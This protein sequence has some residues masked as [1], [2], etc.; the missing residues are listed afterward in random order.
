MLS[1]FCTFFRRIKQFLRC[2]STLRYRS[3]GY[4]QNTSV[5]ASFDLKGIPPCYDVTAG[6]HGGTCKNQK[7]RKFVLFSEAP[8]STQSSGGP[9]FKLGFNTGHDMSSSSGDNSEDDT[10][11]V[12]STARSTLSIQRL[13]ASQTQV[14]EHDLDEVE[15]LENSEKLVPYSQTSQEDTED[16]ATDANPPRFKPPSHDID[17]EKL[18]SKSFAPATEKKILWATKLYMEWRESRL[19]VDQEKGDI[20]KANLNAVDIDPEALC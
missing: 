9:I 6:F 15:V 20:F 2:M 17:I 13:P 12:T 14:Y 19:S 16:N 7:L 8:T 18:S 4:P 10:N 11:T 3:G 1:L 5:V